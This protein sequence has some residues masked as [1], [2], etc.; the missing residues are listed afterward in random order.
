VTPATTTVSV[1]SSGVASTPVIAGLIADTLPV[2]LPDY[3]TVTRL[4]TI[5][6]GSISGNIFDL[7]VSLSISHGWDSDLVI[8]LKGPNGV[9]ISLI[10]QRGGSSD[11]FGGS[12]NFTVLDDDSFTHIGQGFAPFIGSFRPEQ[13]FS[14]ALI[15]TAPVP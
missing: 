2:N 12:G 6:A 1:T 10:N 11:H 3:T 14:R 8:T 15:R 4:I 13:P 9:E 7:D 5:P